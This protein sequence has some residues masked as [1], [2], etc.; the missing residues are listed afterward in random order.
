MLVTFDTQEIVEELKSHGFTDDQASALTKIQKKIINESMD[1][2]LAS[3]KDVVDA[4]T[5]LK[6]DIQ[7][8]N[9]QLIV[10]KWMLGIVIAVEIL[11]LLKQLF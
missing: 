4:K 11:P 10:V 8:L 3:K 2:A 6:I 7:G 5:E 1:N 9:T